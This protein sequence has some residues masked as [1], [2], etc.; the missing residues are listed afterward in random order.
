MSE[1]AGRMAKKGAATFRAEAQRMAQIGKL[2]YRRIRLNQQAHGKLAELGGR[3]YDHAVKDPKKFKLDLKS[4][5][6]ITEAK[7]IEGQ[8]K[9][10]DSEIQKLSKKG[11]GRVA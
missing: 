6:L 8:I 10:L 5:K 3:V 11:Q 1:Q 4:Q 9:K 7:Q 2:R